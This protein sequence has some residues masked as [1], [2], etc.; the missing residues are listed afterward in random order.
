MIG[1]MDETPVY[2][3]MVPSKT[4]NQKGE[5][6]IKVGSTNSDKQRV[7]RVATGH[8]LPPQV[9]FKGRAL[10]GLSGKKGAVITHQVNA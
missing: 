8:M 4:I 5:K 9:I 7:T 6:T 10:A 1:N 2:F 3:D